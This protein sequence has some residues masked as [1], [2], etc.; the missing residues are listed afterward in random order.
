VGHSS[1]KESPAATIERDISTPSASG[2]T[3]IEL[4]MACTLLAIVVATLVPQMLSASEQSKQTSLLRR[5]HLVRERIEQFRDSH[6]GQL[7][8]EGRN[9]TAEFLA[10]LA[11]L[12]GTSDSN[13]F[14][15][16]VSDA[17][18]TN[19]PEIE[20]PPTN[21]YTQRSDILVIPDRLKPHHFSG[22]GHH[23]WA[24][25]SST[26]E[27]RANLSPQITD[28]SGRLINQL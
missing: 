7:P 4:L 15:R 22:N 5:L 1:D 6:R 2:F 24:Y 3:P 25:S 19:Q 16:S 27:F 8:A 21:P 14:G 13:K 20:I 17:A 28:S 9:S 10:D 12:A 18:S 11:R 26:G 23:G